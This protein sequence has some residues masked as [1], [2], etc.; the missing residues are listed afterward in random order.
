MTEKSLRFAR[1]LGCL[2]TRQGFLSAKTFDKNSSKNRSRASLPNGY[3]TKWSFV[4]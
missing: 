1:I 2:G 4:F 3:Y